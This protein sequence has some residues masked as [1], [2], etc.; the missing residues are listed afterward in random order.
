MTTVQ[1]VITYQDGGLANGRVVITCPPFTFNG[2]PVAASQTVVEVVDGAFDVSLYPN[3]NATPTGVYYT[4][5]Y[6]LEQGPIYEEYWIIPN[7]PTVNIGQVRASFP[8]TPSIMINAAQLTSAGAAAGQFLGWNGANWVPMYVSTFNYTPNSTGLIL[9][10]NP[11][12]DLG[13]SGSPA[14]LGGSFTLN[15]PDAGPTSRGVVTTGVQT[16]AGAKTFSGAVSASGGI[17]APTANIGNLTVTGALTVAGSSNV[18]PNPLTTLGD[19]LVRGAS[20]PQRFGVGGD[21]TVLTA[22]STQPLGVRWQVPASGVSSVF[23][24]QGVVTARP[25]D[26]DVSMVTNAVPMSTQILPGTGL[27]GGGSLTGNVTLNVA[28]DTTV[29]QVRTLSNGTL[30]ATRSG[31]NF[32][33]GANVS[34]LVADDA[35]NNAADVTIASTG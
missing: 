17:T 32:I 6:E 26:Y 24:R 15:V 4:A 34:I 2:A 21:G 1:D 20:A 29:Q 3:M 13:V 16:F 30:K 9:T 11:A 25:G 28:N 27:S 7:Q 19:L 35:A 5:E 8:L 31:I 18:M 23:G 14:T 22:D 33:A 12:P 10:E